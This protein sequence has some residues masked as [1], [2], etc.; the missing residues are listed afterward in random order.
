[1][2]KTEL[3]NEVES[4]KQQ[5]SA[6][7]ALAKDHEEKLKAAE[8]SARTSQDN[9]D[10]YQKRYAEVSQSAHLK[11]RAL[12]KKSVE[13]LQKVISA[14]LE[15]LRTQRAELIQLGALAIEQAR[16]D[17]LGQAFDHVLTKLAQR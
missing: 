4:L 10:F 7:L 12:E 5:L 9:C 13:S 6:A 15:A 2:N 11:Y 8:W 14:G 17:T 16:T 1:M 3:E